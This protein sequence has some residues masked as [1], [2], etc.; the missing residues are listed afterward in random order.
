M[1]TEQELIDELERE[2]ITILRTRKDM[3]QKEDVGRKKQ[4]EEK[5]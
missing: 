4:E 3:P 5:T 2:K 1:P